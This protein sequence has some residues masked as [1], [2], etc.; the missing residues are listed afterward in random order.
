MLRACSRRTDLA[1]T[2]A[3]RSKTTWWPAWPSHASIGG[4]SGP[5]RRS[6][7]RTA[8]PRP[9]SSGAVVHVMQPTK[10]R[11]GADRAGAWLRHGLRRLQVQAPM[12]A[13]GVVVGDVLAEHRAEVA[14][15][16]DDE[17]V[18]ALPPQ[19]A[20]HALGDRVG[21]GRPDRREE[22]RDAQGRSPFPEVAAVDG[23]AIPQQVAGLPAPRR[24]PE[25]LPPDPG[26]SRVGGDVDVHQLPSAMGDEQ[27]DVQRL[28]GQRL[29]GEQ[30]RRPDVAPAVGQEDPAGLARSPGAP[31][32]SGS[33]ASSG[34]S[35]RCQASV[36]SIR[37]SHP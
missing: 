11:A 30:I 21:T 2:S 22:G 17:V 3:G 1:A 36:A 5:T 37:A 13:M 29:D 28:E 26:G 4:R 8:Q 25:Q 34:R 33:D 12:R 10:D 16:Q 15:V 18:Q 20:D 6:S 31:P 14:L 27:Q 35:R 24:R 32:G 7:C 9:R 19:R 23:V